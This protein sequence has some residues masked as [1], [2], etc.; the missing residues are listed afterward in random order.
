MKRFILSIGSAALLLSAS[1]SAQF[2]VPTYEPSQCLSTAK[3]SITGATDAQVIGIVAVGL[4]IPL[5]TTSLSLSMSSKDGKSAAWVYIVRSAS[6]DTTA[7]V[8]LIRVLFSCSPP[9]L[10]AGTEIPADGLTDGIGTLPLP[11]KFTQG[12]ALITALKKSPKFAAFST[13]YPDSSATL[14]VLTS[15]VESVPGLFEAGKFYWILNW[16]AT[17]QTDPGQGGAFSGLL[18]VNN[19]ATGETTCLDSAD[20]TSVS[21]Y[22]RDERFALAPNPAGD[23]A[24]LTLPQSLVGSVVDLEIVSVTGAT[25]PLAHRRFVE[26]A[27]M[28]IDVANL[29]T[30]MYSLVIRSSTQNFIVPLSV[31]R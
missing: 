14:A 3:A 7:I 12:A 10:P 13:A 20:F 26:S 29:V 22:T 31:H 8:P 19:I 17:G 18:C 15:A 24:V 27:A 16:S 2:S 28:V 4:D 5:G 6:K 9:P 25:T 11:D 21:D 30:G 23:V 1:A